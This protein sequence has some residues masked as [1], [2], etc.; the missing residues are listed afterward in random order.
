M[1]ISSTIVN[2]INTDSAPAYI[3]AEYVA[4]GIGADTTSS[5]L[6]ELKLRARKRSQPKYRT[7]PNLSIDGVTYAIELVVFSVSCNSR[8]F[9]ISIINRDDITLV[10]TIN[11]VVKYTG[12]NLSENDQDFSR[13]IIRNRDDELTN[14]VYVYLDNHDTISTGNIRIELA[15]LPIQDNIEF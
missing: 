5:D 1:A 7:I 4:N 14:S 12:I 13:F 6:I 9:D 8:N 3:V 10:N 11:E 15:Y 2:V